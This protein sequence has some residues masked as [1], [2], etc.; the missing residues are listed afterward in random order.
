MRFSKGFTLVELI[1]VIAIVA[2]LVVG[3]IA[4]INPLAQ[5]GKAHDAQRKSDLKQIQ[6]ALEQYYNDHGY[7]PKTTLASY[8]VYSSINGGSWLNGLAS[9][10][11][12]I[13]IDPINKS[14][15]TPPWNGGGSNYT[16]VYWSD[17]WCTPPG[18]TQLK[19]GQFYELYAHLENASDPQLGQRVS[20]GGCT[21]GSYYAGW[22]GVTN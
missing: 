8:N 5:V 16:Y 9:Y 18:G 22:I 19:A 1:T 11:N 6:Y 3:L 17:D 4:I 20:V 13:P 21:D 2:V 10:M 12:K 14:D 7:Y 15:G